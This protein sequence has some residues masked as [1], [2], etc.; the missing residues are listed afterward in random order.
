VLGAG[1]R[2]NRDAPGSPD[3]D[4]PGFA[5]HRRKLADPTSTTTRA[6]TRIGRSDRLVRVEADSATTQYD[7]HT[8][9]PPFASRHASDPSSLTLLVG[10]PMHFIMQTR[11]FHNLRTRVGAKA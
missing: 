10:E 3:R 4:A 6:P 9:P 11:Q 1:V 2:P 8:C 5:A 7:F